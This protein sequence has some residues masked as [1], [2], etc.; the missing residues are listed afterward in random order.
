MSGFNRQSGT[1]VARGFTLVELLV[2][3]GIIAVL[4]SILMPT[5][6]KVRQQA[7]KVQCA[8]NLR[9]WGMAYAQYGNAN[10]GMFPY[11]GRTI[12]NVVDPGGRD[13]SWNSA[14]QQQF[15]KDFLIKNRSL[16]MRDKDNVLFCPSQTWHREFQN[17]TTLAGGLMGYFNLPYRDPTDPMN[18][19]DYTAGGTFPDGNGWVT[20]KKLAG[21][22]KAAPIMSDMLQTD[23]WPGGWGRYSSHLTRA[24]IPSGGNFLFEDGHVAWYVYSPIASATQISVGATAGAWQCW[25]RIKI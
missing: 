12:P 11:N 7:T 23:S 18:T 13:L 4:I 24:I 22:Y 21:H 20:R 5:L 2:V 17:D 3:I 6:S 16:E 19:M 25:Y 1:P 14:V 10:K 8:S 15:W 9:Q